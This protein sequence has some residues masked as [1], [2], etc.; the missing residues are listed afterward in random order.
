MNTAT[1]IVEKEVLL[2]KVKDWK[3]AGEKIVFSNG[4]FDIM[5]LGHVDYLEKARNLGDR[6]IVGLNT[7][8]SVKGLKGEARPIVP[9][10]ARARMLAALEFVDA[11]ILFGEETPYNLIKTILPDILVKGSDYTLESVVG[12]DIVMTNNGKVEFIDLV[13]GFSTTKI[14][15]RIKNLN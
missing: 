11:V 6:L 15:N 1:K 13:N 7:D 14:I 8:N 4:C 5:H 12:A 3:L 9:E 2:Q 10:Y